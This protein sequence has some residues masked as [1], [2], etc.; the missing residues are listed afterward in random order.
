MGVD[1]VSTTWPVEP[2]VVGLDDE[3]GGDPVIVGAK[4][5]ALS[6]ARVALACRRCRGSP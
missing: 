1:T 4:A 5:A 2:V 6:R 3:G